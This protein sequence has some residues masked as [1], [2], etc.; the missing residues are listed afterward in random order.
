MKRTH[1]VSLASVLDTIVEK[2]EMRGR[3]SE[4]RAV[5]LWPKVVGSVLATKATAIEA[6][7]G[8]LMLRCDVPVLRQEIMLNRTAILKNINDLCGDRVLSDIR[9]V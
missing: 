6:S 1:P 3:M 9:F 8:T 7:K 5:A 4:R 2:E